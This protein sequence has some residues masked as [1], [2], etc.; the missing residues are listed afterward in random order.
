V[1]RP[2]RQSELQV[3][4]GPNAEIGEHPLDDVGIMTLLDEQG[5]SDSDVVSLNSGA[6]K[7]EQILIQTNNDNV[8]IL[9]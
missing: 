5:T 3:E 1:G 8:P 9:E 2:A 6:C 4:I 7:S